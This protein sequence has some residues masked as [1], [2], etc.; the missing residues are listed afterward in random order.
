MN[1]KI[2]GLS[3]FRQIRWIIASVIESN[4]GISKD[5]MKGGIYTT[6]KPWF[7]NDIII[8][9]ELLNLNSNASIEFIDNIE[10]MLYHQMENKDDY[11]L[12]LNSS[13]SFL[14]I[15]V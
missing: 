8:Y 6:N 5:T 12:F 1:L 7:K 14:Y 9:V 3:Y 11:K 15:T 2:I 4:L 10:M 13:L